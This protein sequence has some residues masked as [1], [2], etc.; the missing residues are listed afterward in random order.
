M[1]QAK[2][3]GVAESSELKP[4][5][6][7]FAIAVVFIFGLGAIIGLMAVMRHALD[8]P[9]ILFFMMLSFL[10]MFVVESVFIWMLLGHSKRA[11]EAGDTKPFKKRA[12]RDLD[13]ANA[14][15]LSEPASGVTEH[16]T[17]TL[18][19]ADSQHKTG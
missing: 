7:V 14:H 2:G 4:E 3:D 6:L 10:A 19:T 8:L 12:V 15:A 1:S 17:R 16:T 18:E 5:T 11:K 9:F 13:G